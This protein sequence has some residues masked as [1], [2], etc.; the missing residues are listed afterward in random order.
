MFR[1]GGPRELAEKEEAEKALIESY[2]PAGAGEEEIDAAIA[3]ALAETGVTS[4]KQM[5]V[6]MKAAQAKLAGKTVDGK[7]LSEKVRSKLSMTPPTP[8]VQAV[9]A[10]KHEDEGVHLAGGAAGPGD[11][12]WCW[13]R[14]TRTWGCGR[15]DD[16]GHL[17]GGGD[18]HGG[19]AAV[20][21]LDPRREHRA[22]RGVD[23]RIGGG[24]RDLH[25]S[26]VRAWSKRVADRSISSEAYW[27]STALMMVGG[28]LGVLFV[29]LIRRVMVED[30]E[31]PFPESVAAAEIH[32]A[33]QAGAKRRNICSTTW[34]S[35]RRSSWRARSTCSRRTATSSSASGQLGSERAAA[36]RRGGRRDGA[37]GGR[38]LHVRGADA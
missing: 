25:D 30:P 37:A 31:L 15:A 5:G 24:G 21:G 9:R 33:G 11:D 28:V 17:S 20:Q 38:R 23:R 2:L 35:A 10:G 16:C 27:K 6:V 14:P 4:L 8:K 18:R 1:K 19:A 12:A 26:G 29:S 32:K 34:L 7:A 3:A 22:N 13:A 36:G